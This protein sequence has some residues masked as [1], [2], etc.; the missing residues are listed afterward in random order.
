MNKSMNLESNLKLGIH[1]PRIF[2]LGYIEALVMD[3]ATHNGKE[4]EIRKHN[5]CNKSRKTLF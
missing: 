2:M 4:T 3:L 5:E 1:K